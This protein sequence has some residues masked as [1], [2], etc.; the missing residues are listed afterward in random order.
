MKFSIVTISYNQVEYIEE[1]INSVLNQRGVELEYIVVDAGSSDGSRDIILRYADRINKIIFEND[2]GPAD[3][4]NKGFSYATGD[5]YGYLNSDDILF[6]GSLF[7]VQQYFEKSKKPIDV[8]SGHGFVIDKYSIPKYKIFSN[9][10]KNNNFF[11]KRYTL[12]LSI[13]VQPS[14]FISKS[15]FFKVNSFDKTFKVMWDAALT[16][17]LLL[18]ECNFVVVNEYFSGFRIYPTSITGSKTQLQAK[19][20]FEFERLRMRANVYVRDTL[21]IS[22]YYRFIGW[23]LEPRLLF[24][25]LLD[26]LFYNKRD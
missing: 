25:R 21:L 12:G 14:T 7:K 15:A 11:L 26:G 5:I 20:K 13:L 4:L 10:L 2:E 9:K 24:V 22:N 1:S 18:A 8:I 3:G 23:L 19:G 16:V 17:D 6:P